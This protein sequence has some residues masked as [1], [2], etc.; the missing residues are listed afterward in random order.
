M[1]WRFCKRKNG[2]QTIL[3][4][5]VQ[6]FPKSN[7]LFNLFIYQCPYSDHAN[8]WINPFSNTGGGKKCYF[9]LEL[10]PTLIPNLSLIQLVARVLTTGVK[11]PKHEADQ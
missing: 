8:I 6:A 1:N 4:Q 9:I 5:M 10:G 11:Q 2:R 3:N 7:S